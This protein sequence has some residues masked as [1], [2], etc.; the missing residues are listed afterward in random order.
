MKTQWL[1]T[2]GAL[3]VALITYTAAAEEKGEDRVKT[4]NLRT[5][6]GEGADKQVEILFEGPRRKIVQITLRHDAILDAHK[7]GEP[8]T[9]HCIAGT[10]TLIVG[11]ERRS[12]ELVPGALVTIEPNTI[13]EIRSRPSVSVLLSKFAEN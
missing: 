6:I 11:E 4:L 9:I 13:H 10:G 1:L 8:I 7:A 5:E 3:L 2:G 12:L